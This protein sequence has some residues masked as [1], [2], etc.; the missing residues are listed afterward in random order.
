M[1]LDAIWHIVQLILNYLLG[2]FC[3]LQMDKSWINS[4]PFG[5]AH[6]DGVSE[7]MKLVS[8]KFDEDAQILCPC[9]RCLNRV[10]CHKG[11]VEDHLL[12]HGMASTYTNWI[13][14]GEGSEP[15]INEVAANEDEEIG[16][17]EDVGLNQGGEED[18]DDDRLPDMV[19]EYQDDE[20]D[21]DGD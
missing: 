18:P 10:H 11:Q 4:R 7:F 5:K 13:Y 14:H 17:N 8:E 9:R 19:H 6:L 2:C 20:E 16:F 15:E 3:L 21:S 1:L 12:L